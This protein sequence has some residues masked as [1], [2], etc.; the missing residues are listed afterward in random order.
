MQTKSSVSV[1]INTILIDVVIIALFCVTP[2]IMHLFGL[3][4]HYFEPM[5]VAL[6]AGMLIVADK[7]NSYLLA[8]ILPISSMILSGMPTPLICALMVV[9]LM[10]N[11]MLFYL[12]TKPGKNAIAGMFISIIVSKVVFRLMK[13]LFVSSIAFNSANLLAN[14]Q[15]QL[16]MSIVLACAFGLLM[17]L[18]EKRP[19]A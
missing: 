19:T 16:I 10:L 4:Y 15:S 5:R 18:T 12:L 1:R 17:K 11:V 9:E 8:A 14:W 6:F 7:K 2:A 13:C 3:S